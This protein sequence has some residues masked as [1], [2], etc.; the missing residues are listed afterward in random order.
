M[1]EIKSLKADQAYA[2]AKVQLEQTTLNNATANVAQTALSTLKE[3]DSTLMNALRGNGPVIT[4][5][6]YNDIVAQLRQDLGRFQAAG[7]SYMDA[8]IKNTKLN[9]E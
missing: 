9:Q 3:L 6:E 8:V 5:E 2:R 4:Y 1:N 7:Q